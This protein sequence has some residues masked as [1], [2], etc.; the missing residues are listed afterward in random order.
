MAI[1]I[2]INVVGLVA[3]PSEEVLELMADDYPQKYKEYIAVIQ[4][5]EFQATLRRKT[6]ESKR[7]AVL[8]R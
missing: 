2:I 8:V 7:I 5:R 6:M 1:T 3:L 4:E